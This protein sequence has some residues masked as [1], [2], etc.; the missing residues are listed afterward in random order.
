MRLTGVLHWNRNY[1]SEMNK[2]LT[3]IATCITLQK[4]TPQKTCTFH[5]AHLLHTMYFHQDLSIQT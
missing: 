1:E 4:K 2:N 3:W 5:Y